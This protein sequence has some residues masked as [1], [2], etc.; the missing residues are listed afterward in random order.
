MSGFPN[1]SSNAFSITLSVSSIAIPFLTCLATEGGKDIAGR[2]PDAVLLLDDVGLGDDWLGTT[3]DCAGKIV[4][5]DWLEAVV[6]GTGVAD[7]ICLYIGPKSSSS[8]RCITGE[9]A[10]DAASC[11]LA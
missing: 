7:V 4:G 1:F 3:G 10:G 5:D 11:R 2:L 8:S 9:A 6:D